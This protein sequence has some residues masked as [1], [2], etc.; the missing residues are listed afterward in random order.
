[1]DCPKCGLT[2]SENASRCACGYDFATG[3]M[4]PA[5][6][7]AKGG[8]GKDLCGAGSLIIGLSSVSL[9]F[10]LQLPRFRIF[11]FHLAIDA[12]ITELLFLL[13]GIILGSIARGTLRWL[14]VISCA[15]GLLFWLLMAFGELM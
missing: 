1:M 15:V 10:V 2:K 13:V 9:V 4:S 11:D 3:V 8:K 7:R 12:T 14:G 6:M 5:E